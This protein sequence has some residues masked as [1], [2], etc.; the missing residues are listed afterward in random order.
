MSGSCWWSPRRARRWLCGGTGLAVVLGLT[1]WACTGDRATGPSESPAEPEQLLGGNGGILGTGLGAQLL[2]C[3]P[4]PA[5]HA[6]SVIGPNGGTVQVGPHQL[7]VPAGALP[8]TLTI[9]ADAP[10]DT[11]NSIRFEPQGLQFEAG[12]PARL[13]MS[14]ANCPLL[15]KLLPK[16]IAYTTDLLQILEVL[17]SLDNVLLHRVSA[18]I[19][20]FSR[21]AIAW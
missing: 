1:L 20:H 5:A 19:V 21:Y 11:V 14:Y 9:T 16:R 18:D 6:A 8:D 3:D 4:L 12:H 7:V 15:A 17:L 10:S 2:R 13:T